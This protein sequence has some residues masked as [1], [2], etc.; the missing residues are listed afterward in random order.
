MYL[1]ICYVLCILKW[2]YSIYILYI[3]IKL[4]IFKFINN[5]YIK[6]IK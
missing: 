4:Y 5:F 1:F 2:I 3:Y 6:Y